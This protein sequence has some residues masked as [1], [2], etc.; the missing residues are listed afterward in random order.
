MLEQ[1]GLRASHY[2]TSAPI[3]RSAAAPPEQ[4]PTHAWL[5]PALVRTLGLDASAQAGAEPGGESLPSGPV[6]ACAR[7]AAY[8]CPSQSD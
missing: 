5:P 6:T 7:G 4:R 2:L 1:V 3:R 8:D